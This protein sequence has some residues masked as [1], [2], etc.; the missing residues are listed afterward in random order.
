MSS[1]V[2]DSHN[3]PKTPYWIACYNGISPDGKVQRFKRS[4]KVPI[5]DKGS[6]KKALKIAAELEEAAKLA[7]QHRLIASQCQKILASCT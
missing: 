6:R 1:V 3:P 2:K 7:G 4:T 5:N